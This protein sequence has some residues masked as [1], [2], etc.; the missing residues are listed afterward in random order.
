MKTLHFHDAANIFP[1]D[2][3]NLDTLAADIKEN[4]QQVPIELIDGK[5]VDGRRRYMACRIAEV[6][7]ATKTVNPDDPVAYVLSLNLHRRHLTTSQKAMVAAKAR[8]VYDKAAKERQVR[9]PVDSVVANF[10]PQKAR[11]AAGAAMGISGR[12]VDKASKV[13]REGSPE[14]VTAVETNTVSVNAAEKIA[15]LPKEDQPAAIESSGSTGGLSTTRATEKPQPP[16][17]LPEGVSRGVGIQ[18]GNAAIDA[19]KRIP[20]ND[21]LRERGFQIVSDWIKSNK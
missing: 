8:G 5:I 3:E 19:L 17:E 2:D 18:W 6:E 13:L 21:G 12:S 10:P 7:P 9:K 11:D 14:L 20:K 16:K 15:S 4:G 1:M